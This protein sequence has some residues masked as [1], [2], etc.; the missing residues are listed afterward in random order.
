MRR[1]EHDE[2]PE[3]GAGRAVELARERAE[4]ALP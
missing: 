2:D 1:A 3:E 4:A